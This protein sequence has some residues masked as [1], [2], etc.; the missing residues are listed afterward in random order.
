LYARYTRTLT[1]GTATERHVGSVS[2]KTFADRLA[3]FHI[4]DGLILNG[5]IDWPDAIDQ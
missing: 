5:V 1:S 2:P 4:V 3:I